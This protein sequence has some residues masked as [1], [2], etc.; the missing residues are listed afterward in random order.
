MVSDLKHNILKEI[1]KDKKVIITDDN[2]VRGTVSES[3]AQNPL[4]AGDAE[5][6]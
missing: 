3:V 6:E 5:V 1:V 4:K 2:I